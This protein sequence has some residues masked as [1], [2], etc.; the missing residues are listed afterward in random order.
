M[1]SIESMK[2]LSDLKLSVRF[3][4]GA[5]II[6]I[7]PLLTVYLIYVEKSEQI[8]V[9]AINNELKEKAYL[10]G[11][12]I[13]RLI[14]SY[15]QNARVTSQ[16]DVFESDNTEAISNYLKEIVAESSF[17]EEADV[18]D[19]NGNVI[20]TSSKMS[21]VDHSLNSSYSGFSDLQKQ[22]VDGKQGDVF[23][24]ELIKIR[25][26]YGII[27]MTPITDDSNQNVI[28]VLSIEVNLNSIKDS[29]TEFDKRVIG[30]KYVYIVDNDG[31]IILTDD[32]SVQVLDSF[33]DLS[34]RP[35]LL[36]KFEN[37]GEVGSVIYT[38]A[39]Q[40]EVMA[41]YADMA[42]F[43]VN[44]AL[45]WSLIAIAPMTDITAPVRQLHGVLT[46][47][48][49]AIVAVISIITFLASRGI[50]RPIQK[51]ALMASEV[52]KGNL[53]V[54]LKLSK[55]KDEIGQ[56]GTALETM[57]G[58]LVHNDE[59]NRHDDWF[60]QGVNSLT[61][62]LMSND[63]FVERTNKV[64]SFLAST[65]GARVGTFYIMNND[66]E[67]ELHASYAFVNRK[68]IKRQIKEGE[69]IVGQSIRERTHIV[70]SKVPSDYIAIDSSLGDTP[71]Q[72]LI[73]LPIFI[74]DE[75]L[76]AIELGALEPFTEQQVTFLVAASE[77]IATMVKTSKQSEVTNDLLVKTQDLAENL[78]TQQEEL[79][80][81]N[82]ELEE[83]TTRLRASEEEL[84]A[85]QEELRSTNEEL[86][87]KNRALQAQQKEIEERSSEVQQAKDEITEKAHELE[88]S[89]KYK[90][91][92]LANMS[93]EIRTPLNSLLVLSRNLIKNREA[94]LSEKQINDIN[95]I[96]NSGG[97][98]LQMLNEILDLSK[99]E[100]G[101]M[102]VV[103]EEF[104]VKEILSEM[105]EMFGHV[106]EDKN[107]RLVQ[108][109]IPRAL[110]QTIVSDKTKLTQ[111][112]RNLISNSIKFTSKGSV[113]ISVEQPKEDE[114]KSTG[115]TVN[116]SI[117]FS[118]R[119][120]GIGIG[121]NQLNK[122]FD[123][124]HQE[125]GSTSRS[126]GGTGLG[127]TI[128]KSLTEILGGEVSV[129]AEEGK[130]A[131]FSI[132]IPTILQTDQVVQDS[133]KEPED[134]TS[135]LIIDNDDAAVAAI[136]S[137]IDAIEC[138][139][140]TANSFKT[141]ID[142]LS[143]HCYD[144]VI[145]DIAIDPLNDIELLKQL[146][147]KA[148]AIFI[149]TAKKLNDSDLVSLEKYAISV[150][151]K[152][153]HSA[154]RLAEEIVAYQTGNGEGALMRKKLHEQTLEEGDVSFAGEKI[155]VIDDDIRNIYAISEL[156]E[157]LNLAVSKSASASNALE[158]LNEINDF[159]LII[160][161]I[162]M[163]KMDGFELIREI[164]KNKEFKDI[165]IIALTAKVM[166]QD[167]RACFAA[168]ANDYLVKPIDAQ[169]LISTL[170]VWLN[171]SHKSGGK[172]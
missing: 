42:E 82:E 28:K 110:P 25:Q 144:C 75:V 107:I 56:L 156:L 36:D 10:V 97:D 123:A 152:S 32:P 148:P 162:M 50:T 98:L 64:I 92:F 129:E 1:R 5:L 31:R 76:G 67:L 158:T 151:S 101:K 161:D 12:N 159:D 160:T 30:E 33:P 2:F 77:A 38:D 53:D 145:V 165:P 66:N 54:D 169:K 63:D 163:S 171:Q 140:F 69:G 21:G 149:N 80:S 62:I 93:H 136:R 135:V 24:S 20:A 138:R 87:E 131:C 47:I 59:K 68:S 120:T 51:A 108:K 105:N 96:H 26:E 14:Q 139:T 18:F 115:L 29:V 122:I 128:T 57:L 172:S 104:S 109:K 35:G 52:S 6:S 113:T 44:Q 132:V 137:E 65:V 71:P 114:L 99:I 46:T 7:I 88:L 143:Q 116:N 124:F 168:G 41:G 142:E 37:Q 34:V 91:E 126:Y 27:L 70:L 43:G 49:F 3:I 83:Q 157:P 60:K 78:Q 9:D 16:A 155:L 8:I 79:R 133:Y 130:G 153:E 19:L 125:D 112:L 73:S 103:S 84:Q 39:T 81:S 117:K 22:A 23:V 48:T 154:K 13:D 15:V 121:D 72:A 40:T 94:N 134:K 85:Q 55:G 4:L 17:I 45:D 100:A 170:R 166:E 147:D 74:K 119:D 146:K 167:R 127:L 150:F 141:A 89:T 164:R 95:I 58:T 106:A 86:Q 102:D 90:S 11:H 111:V 118:V 61:K